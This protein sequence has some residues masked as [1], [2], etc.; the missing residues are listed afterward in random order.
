MEPILRTDN[1]N[2][3]FKNGSQRVQALKDVS[4]N[5]FPAKLTLLKGR[6]GS[7]KTTLMNLLGALDSPTSGHVF[8]ESQDINMLSDSKRDLLR[9]NQMGFVFQTLALISQMS[10]FENVDLN[11]RITGYPKSERKKR[12]IEC[13]S[14]VGLSNRMQHR[15]GELSGGEQQRV[16]IARAISHKPK[17]IFADEPTAELD[18][19]LG[20]QVMKMLRNLVKVEGITVVMT[21]HD[22]NMVELVDHIYTMSDGEISDEFF[23]ED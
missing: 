18:T 7:G 11:L 21:S 17:I 10:A 22:P 4:I 13:L 15:P 6:S 3:V 16:A 19:H 14:I 1:I 20:L 2:R 12:A 9:R 23:N 8:F 5:I